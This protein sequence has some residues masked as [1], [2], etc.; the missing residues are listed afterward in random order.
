[1]VAMA[2]SLLSIGLHV[3]IRPRGGDFL[4]TDIEFELMKEEIRFARSARADGVV[5][6]ILLA[7]GSVDEERTRELVELAAPLPLTFHRAFDMARDLDEALEAVIS[8]GCSRVLTSGGRAGVDEGLP[9]LQHLARRS[10][11]RVEIMAGGGVN[12]GNVVQLR[13]AGVD[14]VHL[15]GK[16]ARDSQMIFR[17]PGV[18]MGGVPGVPEYA[19]Y[20]CDTGKVE[21]IIRALNE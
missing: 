4:Y 2:R 12:V 17:N 9:V 16:R 7:D 5:A 13:R 8:A 3:M 18:S 1:M 15:S 10:A 19:C 21:A 11:G 14:A 6:G 20:F